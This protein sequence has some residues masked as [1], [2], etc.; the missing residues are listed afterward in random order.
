MNLEG[1]NS[2]EEVIGGDGDERMSGVKGLM[3]ENISNGE[4]GLIKSGELKPPRKLMIVTDNFAGRKNGLIAFKEG[5]K[6]RK[7]RFGGIGVGE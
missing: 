6:S 2:G 7:V 4:A 1:G 5:S 3:I